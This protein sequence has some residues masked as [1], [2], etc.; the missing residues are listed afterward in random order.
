MSKSR[1]TV[2]LPSE[3]LVD[4]DKE[5]ENRSRFILEAIRRELEWRKLQQLHLSLES[6]HPETSEW[7]K[8]GVENYARSLPPQA[9][10]LVLPG[11][12]QAIRWIPGEGWV[13]E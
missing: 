4:I 1:V 2:T 6:P 11:A 13:K 10:D 12:G 5:D 9:D 3:L 7:E 8:L